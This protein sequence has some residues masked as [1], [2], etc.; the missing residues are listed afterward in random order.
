[1]IKHLAI[2][3]FLVVFVDSQ[4]PPPSRPS[5]Q[6]CTNFE[7]A[8]R[9]DCYPQPDP[10]QE[11]CEARGCC[12]D[13]IKIA[14]VSKAVPSCYY[15]RQYGGYELVN[16]SS[17]A[18]GQLLYLRRTFQSTYPRDVKL[19][20]IDVE[21]QTNDRVRVKI[22]DAENE[23]FEAPYPKIP[24]KTTKEVDDP[25]YVVDTNSTLPFIVSRKDKT[26]M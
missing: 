13:V 25:N 6:Q 12:W 1:M 11:K 5:Q 10:T 16:S 18:S 4:L 24:V 26:K 3:T 22:Y 21:Y 20:R 8:E 17:D 15:P 14:G 9:F 19:V 7:P 23:R 2:V